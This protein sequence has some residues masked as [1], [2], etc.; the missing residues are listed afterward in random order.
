LDHPVILD[1]KGGDYADLPQAY[2][3]LFLHVAAEQTLRMGL[4]QPRDCP[5]R[6]AINRYSE[7]IAARAG[8]RFSATCLANMMGLLLWAM[9][10]KAEESLLWPTFAN[11]LELARIA[12]L[13]AFAAKG[14]YEKS[15]I[16]RLEGLVQ[17]SGELFEAHRGLEIE[18]H[19]VPQRKHLIIE[20]NLLSPAWVRAIATDL[21][22]LQLLMGRQY[23]YERRGTI[24]CLIIA[25][26][27]DDDLSEEWESV[28]AGHLSPVA[29]LIQQGRE[30]GIGVCLGV[31]ALGRVA[32]K[33]LTDLNHHCFFAV[34]DFASLRNAAN[35]LNLPPRGHEI[36]PALQPGECVHRRP[37]S[38]AGAVLAK[39][40]ELPPSRVMRPARFDE[41]PTSSRRTGSSA[42]SSGTNRSLS[43][44][45]GKF[46]TA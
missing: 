27:M 17:A 10:P 2:P 40:D 16:Q 1:R 26:E 20:Q 21:L 45:Q 39:F 15:L 3:G 22:F 23:R 8:L 9:N 46:P 38:W 35:T 43:R 14:D 31:H 42:Q 29:Q 32:S 19:L 24:N 37:G 5:P 25:D 33:I 44:T 41:H 30:A 18:E 11:L 12:P 28:F 13:D 4:Q 34:G 7:I 6:L 36:L